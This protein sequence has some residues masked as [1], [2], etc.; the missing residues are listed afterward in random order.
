MEQQTNLSENNI[1]DLV[2]RLSA[3]LDLPIPPDCR[4][5]VIANLERTATIAQLVL[6][7]PLPETIEPS[8]VFQP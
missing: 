3:F 7:F 6:D 8:P 1:P 2:D 4:P 5:G